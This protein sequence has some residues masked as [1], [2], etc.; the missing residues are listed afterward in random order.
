MDGFERE[1]YDSVTSRLLQLAWSRNFALHPG[2]LLMS[3]FEGMR[4][5]GFDVTV[6]DVRRAAYFRTVYGD[7]R[8][9]ILE[10]TV[11]Y[12]ALLDGSDNRAPCSLRKMNMNSYR[13]LDMMGKEVVNRRGIKYDFWRRWDQF[14]CEKGRD[15]TRSMEAKIL[16]YLDKHQEHMLL[17]LSGQ[18]PELG[19][20]ELFDKVLAD[21]PM[22][23][24]RFASTHQ[25]QEDRVFG[26]PVMGTLFEEGFNNR[27]DE[28]YHPSVSVL[29]KYFFGHYL[30]ELASQ[31]GYT[32][33]GKDPRPLIARLAVSSGNAFD[34]GK[35]LDWKLDGVIS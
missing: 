16:P 27:Y 1:I 28:D 21:F 9:Y 6:D 10:A 8:P 20:P 7:D 11:P 26:S 32:I 2:V 15:A 14:R 35:F 18:I 4:D 24:Y 34:D 22:P 19:R 33:N 3:F 5:Q 17:P 13:V 30:A 23:L 31:K 25:L 29:M 12:A